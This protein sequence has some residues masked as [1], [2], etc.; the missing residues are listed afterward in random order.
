MLI[1]HLLTRNPVIMLVIPV[2]VGHPEND[3]FSW[4]VQKKNAG[5]FGHR[6]SGWEI[7]DRCLEW[8]SA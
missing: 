2:L 5:D 6:P 3:A 7:S 4:K 8:A 1:T